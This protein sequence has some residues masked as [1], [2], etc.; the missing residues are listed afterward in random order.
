MFLPVGAG[1]GTYGINFIYHNTALTDIKAI[2]GNKN[3]KK[4][5]QR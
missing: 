1:T 5:K 2:N 4:T 3:K